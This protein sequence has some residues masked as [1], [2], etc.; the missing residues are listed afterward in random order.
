MATFL[1]GKRQS[2]LSI[3]L[4][5]IWYLYSNVLNGQEFISQIIDHNTLVHIGLYIFIGLTMG[6]VLEKKEKL[7]QSSRSEVLTIQGKYQSLTS[8][9]KDTLIVKEELQDQVLYTDN[10]IALVY[11]IM[12]ELDSLDSLEICAASVKIA[13]E[14]MKSNGASLYLLN[15]AKEELKLEATSNNLVVPG[16]ML[17]SNHGILSDAIKTGSVQVN[18]DL[19]PKQPTMIAPI[20]VD[21]AV[22]GMLCIYNPSFEYLT[23]S[24]QNLLLVTAN[25]ISSA[26]NRANE[27]EQLLDLKNIRRKKYSGKKEEAYV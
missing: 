26:L 3:G 18:K 25:L 5:S 22:V 19:D 20:T 21:G 14:I 2:I 1:F 27:H 16:S 8:V 12:K 9:Y 17:I 15:A 11:S 24:Y 10:S 4:A 7:I 13:G 23:L 6:Y